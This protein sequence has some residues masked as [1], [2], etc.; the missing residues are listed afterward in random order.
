MQTYNEYWIEWCKK[1]TRFYTAWGEGLKI[2]GP[3]MAR[4]Q[5][6][7]LLEIILANEQQHRGVV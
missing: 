3:I 7:R 5:D 6:E 4:R 1:R 2:L